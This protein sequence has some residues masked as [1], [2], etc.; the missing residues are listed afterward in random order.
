MLK[1]KAQI[2][3]FVIIAIV[4]VGL[5]AGYFILRNNTK[6][7]SE[8]PADVKPVYDF[9]QD[10]IKRTGTDAL[11]RIGDRGGYLFITPDVVSV[12]NNVPYYLYKTQ[13]LIPSRSLIESSFNILFKNELEFCIL[14]FKKF[15]K[16]YN[17]THKLNKITT[18][19]ENDSLVISLDYPISVSKGSSTYEF[20]NFKFEKPARIESFL[21]MSENIVAQK[22]KYPSGICLNCMY[23]LKSE[24]NAGIDLTDY[25]NSTIFILRD[26]NFKINNKGYEW[27]FAIK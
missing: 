26:D 25:G 13:T 14:N 27:S 19:I 22:Q 12:N 1:R 15:E 2:T 23:D 16:D 8:I 17:I 4:I 20:N 10:C 18:S 5:I 6:S 7:S 3:V 24:Y 21:K 9:V 11:I